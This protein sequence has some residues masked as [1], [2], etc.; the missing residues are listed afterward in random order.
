MVA[1]TTHPRM[2][3]TKPRLTAVEDLP[4][5]ED[6]RKATPTIDHWKSTKR[7]NTCGRV[8][9]GQHVGRGGRRVGTWGSRGLVRGREAAR[10]AA[11]TEDKI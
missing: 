7:R 6:S 4:T 10:R 9:R 8:G 1:C 3:T 5:K 2:K 11:A